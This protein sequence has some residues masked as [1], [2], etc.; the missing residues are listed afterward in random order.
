M[1]GPKLRNGE[2]SERAEVNALAGAFPFT[3]LGNAERLV[4]RNRERIRFCLQRRK[5]LLWD[6]T[7]WTWDERDEIFQLGDRVMLSCDNLTLAP[8]LTRKFASRFTRPFN[9]IGKASPV[10]YRQDYRRR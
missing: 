8:E 9:I 1:T 3:D 10:V 4:A 6:G 7:R 2:A 5:W